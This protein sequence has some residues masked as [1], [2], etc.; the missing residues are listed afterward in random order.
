L[1]ELFDE[2]SGKGGATARTTPARR[3]IR[4]RG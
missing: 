2:S 3:G 4:A 1:T